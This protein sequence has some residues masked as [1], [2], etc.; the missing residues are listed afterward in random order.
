MEV[1]M[2]VILSARACVCA[3]LRK[4]SCEALGLCPKKQRKPSKTPRGWSLQPPSKGLPMISSADSLSTS[5]GGR[6]PEQNCHISMKIHLKTWYIWY[7]SLFQNCTCHL[8]MFCKSG[9]A[10]SLADAR[11]QTNPKP[12]RLHTANRWQYRWRHTACAW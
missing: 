9:I 10:T 11:T 4:G 2:L 5:Q 3:F 6:S 8:H 7:W 12:Q 1:S